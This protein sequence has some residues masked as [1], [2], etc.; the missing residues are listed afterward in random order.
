M[1]HLVTIALALLV[2]GCL[3]THHATRPS[4]LGV[5]RSSDELLELLDQPGPIALESVESAVWEV[6][7]SG[8]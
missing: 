6:P 7:L 1:R 2:F 4:A 3:A 8:S 5:V